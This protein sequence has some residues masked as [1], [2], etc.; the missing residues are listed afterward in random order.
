MF[1]FTGDTDSQR[2]PRPESAPLPIHTPDMNNGSTSGVSTPS[3][4]SPGDN[5][6]LDEEMA[7]QANT[8]DLDR[9]RIRND[10][11]RNRDNGYVLLK[12]CILSGRLIKCLNK[13]SC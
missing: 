11:L 12:I 4:I 8:L 2:W 9:Q 10:D 3:T 6:N 7:K 5:A 13:Y 1:C